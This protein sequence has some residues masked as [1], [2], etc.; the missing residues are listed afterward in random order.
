MSHSPTL[1]LSNLA[2]TDLE[3]Q[4]RLLPSLVW[5]DLQN[6]PKIG[7][8]TLETLATKTALRT[9][10]WINNPAATPSG[11][12]ALANSTSL[13]ALNVS[14]SLHFNDQACQ[15]HLQSPTLQALDV[16]FCSGL[17]DQAFAQIKSP[18]TLLN[19]QGCTELTDQILESILQLK[20][21]KHLFLAFNQNFTEIALSALEKLPLETLKIYALDL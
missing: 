1:Q 6:C 7:D 15:L 2:L 12:L 21:L 18:L 16:S 10:R 19:I 4:S 3:I 14:G 13:K 5:A 11:Y 17:T 8:K 9:L 20:T